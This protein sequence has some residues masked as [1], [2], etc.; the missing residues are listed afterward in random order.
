VLDPKKVI[1]KKE[2]NVV[3]ISDFLVGGNPFAQAKDINLSRKLNLKPNQN[4]LELL[5]YS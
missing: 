1:E 4:Y 2:T 3:F 5:L